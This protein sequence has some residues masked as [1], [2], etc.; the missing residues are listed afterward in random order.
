MNLKE[1]IKEAREF[2]T[3]AS[4]YSCILAEK[5]LDHS[6]SYQYKSLVEKYIQLYY[7]ADPQEE[8]FNLIGIGGVLK[9]EYNKHSEGFFIDVYNDRIVQERFKMLDWIERQINE[10]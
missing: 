8:L 2:N 9:E 4:S 6:T 10:S 3:Q 7:G 5:F 1:F